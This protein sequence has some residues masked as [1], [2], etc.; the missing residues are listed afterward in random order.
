M[1]LSI[2][3]NHNLQIDRFIILS[4]AESY[5]F[6]VDPLD[7]QQLKADFVDMEDP[8]GTTAAWKQRFQSVMNAK[9]LSIDYEDPMDNLN[10]YAQLTAD[11]D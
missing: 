1:E 3:I 2:S 9:G 8:T 4:G 7:L 6:P 10:V 5:T 11:S